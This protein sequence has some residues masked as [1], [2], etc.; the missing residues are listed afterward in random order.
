MVLLRAVADRNIAEKQDVYGWLVGDWELEALVY[1][2]VEAPHLM[3]EIHFGWVLEGRAIQ[4]T[5]ILP[6]R[7]YGTTLRIWNPAAQAWDIRWFNPLSSHYESQTGRR[8]GDEIVQIGARADGTATR[9][10]FTEITPQ[11]FHWIGE[12]LRPDGKTWLLEGEF[13]AKRMVKR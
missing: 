2:A 4:D 11:S 8:M 5:W 12:S 1:Q 9:W 10:R 3:G 7:M 13:R 6:D